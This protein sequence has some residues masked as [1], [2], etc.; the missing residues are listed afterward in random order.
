MQTLK[1]TEY[2]RKLLRLSKQELAHRYGI[3]G[4]GINKP[5]Q[6]QRIL[7]LTQHTIRP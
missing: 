2:E 3:S 4:E 6:V 5:T 7:Q 1:Q